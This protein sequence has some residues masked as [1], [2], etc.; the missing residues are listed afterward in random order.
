MPQ[1]F[2]FILNSCLPEVL[3]IG[4]DNILEKIN[5][6]GRNDFFITAEEY[7]T[8]KKDFAASVKEFVPDIENQI[9]PSP[10]KNIADKIGKIRNIILCVEEN[11]NK[12]NDFKNRQ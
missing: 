12:G 6:L 8:W 1:S 3:A 5:E 2:K 11:K 9:N 4:K 10:F 7:S